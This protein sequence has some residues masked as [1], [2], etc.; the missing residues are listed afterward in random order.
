M[1]KSTPNTKYVT[2]VSDCNVNN[3]A[4]TVG[5]DFG[6]LLYKWTQTICSLLC[7]TS[8][9]A[10]CFSD[11]SWLL[12]VA[13]GFHFQCYVEVTEFYSVARPQ[14]IHSTI[15]RHHGGFHFL[16]ITNS[17]AMNVLAHVCIFEVFDRTT[18]PGFFLRK[19]QFY[20]NK[21]G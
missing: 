1:C 21:N 8:H 11:S 17:A 4:S 2:Q 6:T 13:I 5:R 15:N 7:L 19:F 10:L 12:R 20:G 16:T 18:M 14:F 9:A 3:S